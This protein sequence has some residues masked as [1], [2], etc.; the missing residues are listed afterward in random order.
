[1]NRPAKPLIKANMT[2]LRARELNGQW[3][4]IAGGVLLG[5][6][7]IFVEEAAQ[8]PLITVWFRCVFGALALLLWG[9]AMGRSK[10]LRLYGSSYWVAVITGTLM[11]VNWA[12]F[13]AAL[14][15]TSIAVATVVFHIQPFWVMIFGL[16]F[17]RETVSPLQ[18]VAT[19]TALGGLTLTTG[20]TIEDL[21]AGAIDDEYI[22]G[23]VMCL[24]GSLCYA[25][26]TV[27][28]KTE[29]RMTSFALAWWQCAVGAVILAWVPLIYGWPSQASAWP[30]LIGLG[31]FHTGLAYAI[32]FAGMA[33]LTLGKI[34]LLQFV[35][36]LTA[37]VVDWVI[38]GRVLDLVQAVG[39]GLMVVA[40][41]AVK[42]A[43]PAAAS[44]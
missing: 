27:I 16:W 13:F 21:R 2:D 37:V 29:R 15:R 12:L 11:I 17:L 43:K 18:W 20:L 3:L 22:N 28:A 32:L 14:S 30:W 41:W 42:K 4:L 10:E 39:V 44:S 38:Y 6:I 40:L 9:L 19:L 33:K 1:M 31:V 7:G 26:V 24:I 25:A 36:P 35:Y 23:L 8:H 5:T 34:A